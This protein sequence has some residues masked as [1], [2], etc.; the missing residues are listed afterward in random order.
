MRKKQ[1][2]IFTT[3]M[4]HLSLA[5]AAQEAFEDVGWKTKVHYSEF[6]ETNLIY[7]PIYL[8]FPTFQKSWIEFSKNEGIIRILNHLMAAS[9][10]KEIEKA[11]KNFKP[12]LVFST[13]FLYNNQI[14]LLKDKY[15]FIFLNLL[16]NTRNL[17]PL[18]FIGDKGIDL[19]YDNYAIE[20]AKKYKLP[21]RSI[22]PVGWLTRK[23]FYEN[24]NPKRSSFSK[25]DFT[26]LFCGG[27]WGA[28]KVIEFLPS[29]LKV[30]GKTRLILVAG[31]GKLLY[32]VFSLFKKTT[33][34]G[35]FSSQG[36][37]SIEVFG[38]TNEMPRLMAESD[39]IVG[40]AG[41]N[42]LFE[43][44]AA[45]KPF[46]AVSHISGTEDSNLKL[47]KE[48]N[49]GWVAEKPRQFTHILNKIVK[50][51]TFYKKALVSVLAE[52]NGNIQAAKKII[53]IAK[54]CLSRQNS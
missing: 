11:V 1:I 51:N 7:K 18:E 23:K 52:R 48:K 28:N 5:Q 54:N 32:R 31:S 16:A 40:K 27:S 50:D 2:L 13:Y 12:N 4:G 10:K 45:G 25:D 34:S 21:Y 47:I 17:H 20:A 53:N 44:V 43:S 41:P 14:N 26:V 24:F 36:S 19:S 38:F 30:K 6:T 15:H 39:L 3:S 35:V 9:K 22:N 37:L 49:L 33:D 46:I 29:F 42:L 8:F